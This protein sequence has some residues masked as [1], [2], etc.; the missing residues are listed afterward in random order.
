MKW[1][2]RF[3]ALACIFILFTNQSADQRNYDITPQLIILGVAQDAGYPQMGCTEKRCMDARQNTSLKRFVSSMAFTNPATGQ[4]WLIDATPDI[5]EQVDL[6][7]KLTKKEFHYLPDGIF[8]THAHIGHYTGLMELGLEAMNTKGV[9]VYT[10]P[11]M[12]KYLTDNGPWSQLVS[13]KN[14]V[15]KDLH[16]DSAIQF[17]Y[18]MKITPFLVPHRDEYSETVGFALEAD[19][20]K[21]VFIPDI[22]KWEKFSRNIDSMITQSNLAFLDGTFYKDG[23]LQGRPMAEVPHPFVEESEKYFAGLSVADKSKIFFIH[24]NHTN[25]LVNESSA[26]NLQLRKRGFHAAK[27]GEVFKLK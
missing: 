5:R 16:D 21:V 4:W 11:R 20:F 1:L 25:P 26:E 12:K 18:T 24:F 10:M 23:E 14:I 6:F 22:D 27:Q 19:Q 8:L 9:P 2:L 17:T 13:R 3:P 15:L 7:Q